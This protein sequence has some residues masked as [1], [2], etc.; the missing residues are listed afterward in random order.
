[1][2]AAGQ[3]AAGHDV[4]G[5]LQDDDVAAAAAK[6]LRRQVQA[7]SPRGHHVAAAAAV[8]RPRQDGWRAHGSQVSIGAVSLFA[9]GRAG[10]FRYF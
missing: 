9:L 7:A 1:M 3:D 6:E 2:D 10:H 4:A 8:G 5:G